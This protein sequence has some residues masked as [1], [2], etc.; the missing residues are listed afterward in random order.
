[1]AYRQTNTIRQTET[2]FKELFELQYNTFWEHGAYTYYDP[3]L[4]FSS[5]EV[6]RDEIY[7]YVENNANIVNFLGEQ[8]P[9]KSWE[10]N[11]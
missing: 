3:K 11:V 5:K 2:Q 10:C 1:M 9:K 7:T 8:S 4:V 6:M